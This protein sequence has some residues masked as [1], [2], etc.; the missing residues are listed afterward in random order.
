[1]KIFTSRSAND[2]FN[3]S[4]LL[5]RIGLPFTCNHASPRTSPNAPQYQLLSTHPFHQQPH[6]DQ[7]SH[8]HLLPFQPSSSIYQRDFGY[9]LSRKGETPNCTHHQTSLTA[10]DLHKVSHRFYAHIH[11]HQCYREQWIH[12]RP[13]TWH[14]QWALDRDQQEM[15]RFG[16]DNISTVRFSPVPLHP[17]IIIAKLWVEEKYSWEAIIRGFQVGIL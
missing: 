13:R 4:R 1:M 15:K 6:F 16:E 17:L 5:S 10:C 9:N 2:V 3:H 7:S 12:M 8:V 11:F 14:H